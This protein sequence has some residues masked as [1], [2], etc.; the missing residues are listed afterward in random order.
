M[1]QGHLAGQRSSPGPEDDPQHPARALPTPAAGVSTRPDLAHRD[2]LAP[3]SGDTVPAPRQAPCRQLAARQLAS[4]AGR[5]SGG[6]TAQVQS[7]FGA[8]A[9][10]PGWDGARQDPTVPPRQR[11]REDRLSCD[12]LG[13]AGMCRPSC[14]PPP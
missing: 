13:G 1:A 10:E 12:Q 5:R 6:T 9:P 11:Q 2:R 3:S 14:Q 7:R 4:G 8:G